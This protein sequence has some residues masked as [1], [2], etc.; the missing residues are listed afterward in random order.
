[1]KVESMADQYDKE[2]T[3]LIK[4]KEIIIKDKVNIQKAIEELDKKRKEALEKVFSLTSDSLNKIYKTLLPGT[5]A[6]L[7]QIDK[8]DL[9][10]GVLET[11]LKRIIRGTKFFACFELNFSVVKI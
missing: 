1:M 6:R 8:Y 9:M 4:K 2:Y 5:M 3:N 7:E 11:K 10:K